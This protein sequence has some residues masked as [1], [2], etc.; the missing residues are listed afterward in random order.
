[1]FWSW[2]RIRRKADKS[3]IYIMGI[4]PFVLRQILASPNSWDVLS[5]KVVW[6]NA[7]HIW[8]RKIEKRLQISRKKSACQKPVFWNCIFFR[9]SIT[10]RRISTIQKPL[11]WSRRIDQSTT[12]PKR[13]GNHYNSFAIKFVFINNNCHKQESELTYSNIVYRAIYLELWWASPR[14]P[15]AIFPILLHS[16]TGQRK[17]EPPDLPFSTRQS[18]SFAFHHTPVWLGRGL[19]SGYTAN[20]CLPSVVGYFSIVNGAI[21]KT[22]GSGHRETPFFAFI[23]WRTAWYFLIHGPR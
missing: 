3:Q 15:S 20:R 21:K 11:R 13:W 2:K 12:Q 17:N 7:R 5:W 8:R 6:L 10:R 19:A 22:K 1:M 18:V 23:E 9:Q 16:L 4:L 14:I